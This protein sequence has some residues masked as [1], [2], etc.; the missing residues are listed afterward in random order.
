MVLKNIYPCLHDK[1][2]RAVQTDVVLGQ[3]M[4]GEVEVREGLTPTDVVVTSGQQRLR[5][6]MAVRV[7]ETTP[8]T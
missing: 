6:G 4:P 1:A 8:G 3:R 5:N 2:G 7:V